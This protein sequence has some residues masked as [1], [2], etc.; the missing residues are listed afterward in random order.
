MEICDPDKKDNSVWL[1]MS[2]ISETATSS[3]SKTV[4]IPQMPIPFKY[5]CLN[6]RQIYTFG[7]FS[8]IFVYGE[9]SHD[10]MFA[11]L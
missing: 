3:D 10:S 6:L 7:T 4:Q 5:V 8:A 11:A 2:P 1:Y 9:I